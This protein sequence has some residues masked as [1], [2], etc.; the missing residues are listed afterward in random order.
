MKQNLTPAPV[1]AYYGWLKRQRCAACD[2]HGLHSNPIE[3]AHVRGIYSH[4]T[5]E[6]THRSH[7][8][9]QAW[10]ALPLCRSC[11]GR[12]HETNERLWLGMHVPYHPQQILTNVLTF[13]TEEVYLAEA[14]TEEASA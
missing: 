3:V 5:R 12:L 10:A 7:K 4:K 6:L 1:R 13:L 8:G 9:V 14:P 11:H 2:T